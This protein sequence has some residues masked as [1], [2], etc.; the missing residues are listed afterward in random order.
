MFNM[1]NNVQFQNPDL[2]ISDATFGQIST[3]YDP[4]IIQLALHLKF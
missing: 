3:T 4:R 1:F 2:T